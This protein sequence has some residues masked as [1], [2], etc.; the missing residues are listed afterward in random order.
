MTWL[1]RAHESAC[2]FRVYNFMFSS[3]QIWMKT[4]TWCIILLILRQGSLLLSSRY[5]FIFDYHFKWKNVKNPRH[6]QDG[7]G[8]CKKIRAI[9]LLRVIPTMTCQV[10]VVRWGMLSGL[11]NHEELSII[12]MHNWHYLRAF[13]VRSLALPL[14]R[15][16]R[17]PHRSY[18]SLGTIL[19][20]RAKTSTS[21]TSEAFFSG[22]KKPAKQTQKHQD[23]QLFLVH[24]EV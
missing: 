3:K 23:M 12:G 24:P 4:R 6:V 22:E 13:A 18:G 20:F 16:M 8:W 14:I 17:R 21:T 7:V 19:S 9:T 1:G 2:H 5:L 15:N 10:R 11:E